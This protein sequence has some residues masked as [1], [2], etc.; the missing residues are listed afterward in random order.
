M[1]RLPH[2]LPLFG[3]LGACL[4]DPAPQRWTGAAARGFNVVCW[5]RG[6]L[7]D[8]AAVRITDRALALGATHVAL[9]STWYVADGTDSAPPQPHAERSPTLEELESAARRLSERGLRVLLKPHV[10]RLDGGSRTELEPRDFQRWWAGYRDYLL[11]VA[12]LGARAEAEALAVGTELTRLSG[13]EGSWRQLIADVRGVFDGRVTYAANWDEVEAVPFSD[14]LDVVGVDA[15]YPLV[16]RTTFDQL[17]SWQE[18][19]KRL[20][21]LDAVRERGI[22]FTEVGAPSAAPEAQARAYR[23]ALI[24]LR[25]S[26]GI[27]FWNL[28][29]GEGGGTHVTTEAA[30]AEIAA[31]W[32]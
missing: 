23:A 22:L 32:R 1:P 14:A 4:S 28:W 10:N 17:V 30:A 2:L 16:T 12:T 20:A 5:Q 29:R 15:Y 18:H 31:A 27:Y 7:A 3:C 19:L 24:A 21:R 9:V 6:C 25:D 8:E 26:G 11:A 13:H